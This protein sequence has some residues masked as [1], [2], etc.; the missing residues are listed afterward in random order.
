MPERSILKALITALILT[1]FALGCESIQQEDPVDFSYETNPIAI[2][3]SDWGVIPVPNN[4]LNPAFQARIPVVVPG[5]PAPEIIPTTVSLPITDQAAVDLKESKGYPA[6]APDSALT[7]ELL[8][9]MNRLDGFVVSIAAE[10]PFSQEVDLESIMI[11]GAEDLPERNI[12][13]DVTKANLFFL[14]ITDPENPL[15][16][17]NFKMLFNYREA[18]SMPYMLTIRNNAAADFP[19]GGVYLIIMTGITETGIK[20]T[21]GRPFEPD[22]YFSFFNT[23]KPYVAAEGTPRSNLVSDQAALWQLEG[24]RQITDYGVKIWQSI[25][26][27]KR[28]RG[29]LINAVHFTIMSNPF[30]LFYNGVNTLFWDA[31]LESMNPMAELSPVD[32][33]KKNDSGVLEMLPAYASTDSEPTFKLSL[34][35]QKDTINTDNIKL[36]K[37]SDGG[38]TD[39]AI[40]VALTKNDETGATVKITPAAELEENSEYMVA[41]SNGVVGENG[42]LAADQV[43]FGLTRVTQPLIDS[44]GNLNSPYLDSR[45]DSIILQGKDLAGAGKDVATVLSYLEFLRL[46]YMDRITWLVEDAQFIADRADLALLWTFTT[47]ASAE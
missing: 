38:A 19:Q 24:A 43:F 44:E 11:Y 7:Q 28:S 36:Y 25:V 2:L 15:P 4:F 17:S 23:E 21:T 40:S 5:A 41:M 33:P 42:M 45:A 27:D 1:A 8:G 39:V 14:D 37:L 16:I 9:G 35:V 3:N 12:T 22:T 32:V 34:P 13:T 18:T 10:I 20:D 26:G 30:A 6:G 29:E 47:G 31:G 46:H